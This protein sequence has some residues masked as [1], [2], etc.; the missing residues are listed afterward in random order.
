MLGSVHDVTATV[1]HKQA[2][3]ESEEK[4]R[5]A[6]QSAQLGIWNL[7]PSTNIIEWDERCRELFGFTKDTFITY[8][9]CFQNI[10]SDDRQR[11]DEA[12]KEAINPESNGAY[13]IQFRT[14]GADGHTLHWLHCSGQ[15][16]FRDN[17]AYRFSGIAQDITQQISSQE[18]AYFSDQQATMAIEGTGAGS[19]LIDLST[20]KIVYSSTMAKILTG[21]TN[22]RLT[23]NVFIQHVHSD[24]I[25]RRDAAYKIAAKTGELNYESRF[26]WPDGSVHWVKV[27]GRFLY[28]KSGK[29]LSLSGIVLDISDRMEVEQLLRNSEE[30]LRSMIEQAPVATALFVGTDMIIDTVNEAMLKFWGKNDKIV[31]MPLRKAVPE[32]VGQPFLNILDQVYKTGETF[33]DY[34]VPA[35]LLVNGALQ[36][37]YFNYTYKPLRNKKGEVFAI[38]DMSIDVTAQVM[39]SKKLKESEERYRQLADELEQR[40]QERTQELQVANIELQDSNSNLE[41]FAYVA[42]HDLQEPLRKIQ[43]FGSRLETMYS[44][45]LDTTGTFMLNRMQD[46]SRRMSLMIDDLLTYSRLNNKEASVGLV[47]LNKVFKEVILALEIRIQDHDAIIDIEEM[48]IIFGNDG[49][50]VQLFQNLVSNAIKY[51]VPD[52]PPIVKISAKPVGAEEL[53]SIPQLLST[54]RYTKI[55]IEDNGIGFEEKY[56]E[57]IFQMF[58]RL[59]GKAE[60]DG[61]GIGLALCKKVVQNHNG[62]ITAQSEMGEGS[63]FITYLPLP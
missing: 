59:H 62:Y 53:A 34:G 5:F 57:R 18:K 10:H 30:S 27:I 4:L 46:A 12:V 1:L 60:Y 3:E 28:D 19:F 51:R 61:S 37:V 49:Q 22:E 63:V 6:L 32:L 50:L 47:D 40:V 39:A 17:V 26:V 24:D 14:C 36:K 9:N 52:R 48:P 43:S 38:M 8:D 35:N 16:Y 20:N 7:N 33:Q 25:G 55:M 11:V 15:A 41:Q 56:T 42:S 21:G 2:R 23:R 54:R 44:D 58:Q 29:P 13:S 31:G 45:T